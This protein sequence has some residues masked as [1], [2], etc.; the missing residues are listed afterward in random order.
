MMFV[1]NCEPFFVVNLQSINLLFLWKNHAK[2]IKM[3]QIF[4]ARKRNTW[5]IEC[6]EVFPLRKQTLNTSLQAVT[7]NIFSGLHGECQY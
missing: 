6:E 3:P 5:V 7:G 1:L 4:N 2:G